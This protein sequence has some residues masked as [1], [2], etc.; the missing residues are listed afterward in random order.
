MDMNIKKGPCRVPSNLL[1]TYLN[2][3]II[4]SSCPQN[5][6]FADFF[7][8]SGTSCVVAN[9]LKIKFLGCDINENAIKLTDKRLNQLTNN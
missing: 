4:D 3:K 7:C 5:G 6:I 8:G 1:L 9:E 2:Y